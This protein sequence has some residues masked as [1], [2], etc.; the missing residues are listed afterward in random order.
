MGGVIA[1]GYIISSMG[2]PGY[3][4][5]YLAGYV[6]IFYNADRIIGLVRQIRFPYNLS[7]FILINTVGVWLF[8]KG[9]FETD[10]FIAYLLGM[11]C[12][13]SIFCFMMDILKGAAES[14]LILWLSGI[15]FEI[16]LVH[17][18]FLGRYSVYNY[19]DNPVI[20][21]AI[22]VLLSCLAAILFQAISNILINILHRN[23]F[24]I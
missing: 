8:Y 6:M 23:K 18:F 4:F 21:F 20:G 17:E 2:L 16:Y 5:P 1:L 13:M 22:L 11:L 15:S 9:I 19:I 10:S 7:Q 12:S 3:M 14:K 24:I